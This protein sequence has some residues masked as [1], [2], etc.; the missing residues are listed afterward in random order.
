LLAEQV[1]IPVIGRGHRAVRLEDAV[2]IRGHGIRSLPPI[3]QQPPK[4]SDV[5]VVLVE[6]DVGMAKK[7]VVVGH[8]LI[9]KGGEVVGGVG[10]S[11]HDSVGRG[12]GVDEP[13]WALR[14]SGPTLVQVT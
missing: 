10:G 5:D 14:G 3:N 9:V 6:E 11:A 2:E 8:G 1:E 7:I 12:T 4:A 13:T